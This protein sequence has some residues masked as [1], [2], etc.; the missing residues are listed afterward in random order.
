MQFT[1]DGFVL[2]KVN[3]A[4]FKLRENYGTRDYNYIGV[5][6]NSFSLVRAEFAI[7][8]SK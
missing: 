1:W 2:E 6:S 3:N 4:N 5:H 7:E 8:L